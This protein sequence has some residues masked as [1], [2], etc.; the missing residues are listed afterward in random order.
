MP[1]SSGYSR[2]QIALHWGIMA[3]MVI[4]FFSHDGMKAAWRTVRRAEPEPVIGTTAYVHMAVGALVLVLAIARLVIRIKRGAPAAPKDSTLLLALIAAA[5]HWSLYALIIV[6]PTTGL[7]AWI[8]VIGQVGELHEA[9]FTVL[10]AL[11]GLHVVAALY[12][13]FILRDGLL[14]RMRKAG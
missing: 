1:Q 14:E 10:L 4:S 3:L 13:Q 7:I 9:L 5:V 6:I 2:A 11:V 12:H 8:G